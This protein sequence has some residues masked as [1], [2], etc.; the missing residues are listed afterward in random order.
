[1]R[2]LALA[3]AA[4]VLV[5]GQP[6]TT[7]RDVFDHGP[8]H[9]ELRAVD[10]LTFAPAGPAV[11]L[12]GYLQGWTWSPAHIR[13]ALGVSARGRLQI[14]DPR[15]GRTIRRIATG[16]RT[17]WSLLAWPRARR[18]VAIGSAS[19]HSSP[20][21]VVNPV[22][23][24]VLRSGRIAADIVASAPAPGGL[25]LLI[26]PPGRI[27]DAEL[28]LID[29]AGHERR[30][31]LPGIAAGRVLPAPAADDV[32]RER[33]PGLTVRGGTA[34]VATTDGRA[35]EIDLATGARRDHP[36]DA[37]QAA[38]Q[39]DGRQRELAF[40]GPH[41]L[42][43]SG[44]DSTPGTEAQRPI[45]LWLIDTRTW[46]VRLIAAATG[47]FTPLQGGGFAFN[48]PR[49]LVVDDAAGRT[50]ATLLPQRSLVNVRFSRH[51]AYLI[52]TRPSHRTWVVDLRSGRIV[53]RLPTAQPPIVLN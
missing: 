12:A 27:A 23:G 10:P 13:V 32:A 15:S 4:A 18:L 6:I 50:R 8:P 30:I 42:A 25:A 21:V 24:T 19:G 26:A 22:R 53:G 40:V 39:L 9:S 11:P 33:S 20:L 2:T 17:G 34:Y 36:L 41:Q 29:P 3:G 37:A 16:R 5:S 44:F 28:A 45:G 52:A 51:Y 14:V 35:V 1:M 46:G 47:G 38:K 43:V 31:A 49:G 48:P 7:V